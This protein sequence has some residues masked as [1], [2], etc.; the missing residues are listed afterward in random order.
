MFAFLVCTFHKEPVEFSGFDLLYLKDYCVVSNRPQ[1]LTWT[2]HWSP[3][4][5][6][7]WWK[8]PQFLAPKPQKIVSEPSLGFVGGV[9]RSIVLFDGEIFI[10]EVLFHIT[11]GRGLNVIEV[12]ICVDYGTLF[13]QNKRRFPGIW[14][15]SSNHDIR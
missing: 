13:Y 2:K 9:R 14:Q 1:F 6:D 15:C 8:R 4:G 12:Y 11:Q 7:R 10:F 5:W 3:L